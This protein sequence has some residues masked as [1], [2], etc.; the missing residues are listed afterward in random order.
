MFIISG[1]RVEWPKEIYFSNR[2]CCCWSTIAHVHVSVDKRRTTPTPLIAGGN[3]IIE[4]LIREMS[5]ARERESR[6]VNS[7]CGRMSSEILVQFLHEA[8]VQGGTDFDMQYFFFCIEFCRT[9]R[10][11]EK[12]EVQLAIKMINRMPLYAYYCYFM[13][14]CSLWY[15]QPRSVTYGTHICA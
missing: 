9:M 14:I 2:F 11:L 3:R 15:C 4:V 10:L 13:P 5:C 1:F 12:A 8:F 7:N 6:Q